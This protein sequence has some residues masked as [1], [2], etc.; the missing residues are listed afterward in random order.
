MSS[1]CAQGSQARLYVEP[2]ASPHTFD[3][4]SERYEFLYETMSAKSSIIG[5]EGIRGTRSQH[6]NNTRQGPIETSGRIAMNFSKGMLDLW[7]PRILGANEATDV[8]A[9]AES[10]PSFGM[11]ID[12]VTQT[13]Q[14]TDCKVNRAIFRGAMSPNGETQP[15]EMILEIIALTEVAGTSV[16]D[17]SLTA[18]SPYVFTDSV[19]TLGGSAKEVKQWAIVIDNRLQPR[20]VNSQTPTRLCPRNRAVGVQTENPFDPATLSLSAVTDIA[21]LVGS[22][23]MTN[24]STSTTFNFPALQFIRNTPTVRGKTEIDLELQMIARRTDAAAEISV[25]NATS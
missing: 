5:G 10:L 12:K 9:V 6:Y 4:S 21:G 19:L 3:S 20:W 2:G 22:L 18:E 16:P 24:G 7:L 23:A 1:A 15:I 14:Y 25:T 13:Y 8:F 17:V 11:L